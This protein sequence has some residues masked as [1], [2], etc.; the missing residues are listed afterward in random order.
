MG[1]MRGSDLMLRAGDRTLALAERPRLMGILN[2]TPDSFSGDGAGLATL[3]AR[4]ARAREL[5]EEG[6]EVIDV[7]GES[8]ITTTPPVAVEEE[9]ERVAPLIERVAAELDVLVSVDTY[10]PAVAAAAVAAGAGMVNDVSGLRDGALADVCA[11]SGAALVVMHTRAEPKRK[12][13]D[14]A[15][16]DVGADVADFLRERM[17]LARERGV[18]EEQLVVDPGPDFAK[19]PEQT[20]E[21]LR[22]LP[23]LAELGR[24]ILLAVSRKDFVGALT[25]RRP[26]DR[27]AGTLAALADG[28]DAGARLLRVHDVAAAA[29]FLAVRAALRGEAPVDPDLALAEGLRRETG[30]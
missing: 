27:G 5:V 17:A 26:S 4:I 7:G 19:T 20:V 10:K 21:A 2:A 22:A 16:G 12:V 13:L 18:T 9:I 3:E 28:V 24:P 1:P 23:A 15:Y 14:H 6:A 25:G 11:R 29:D 8:Q 30:R